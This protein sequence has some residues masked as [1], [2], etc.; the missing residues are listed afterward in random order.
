MAD[1]D[2]E[3]LSREDLVVIAINEE[4]HRHAPDLIP[5][6]WIFTDS[7]FFDRIIKNDYRCAPLTQIIT[8][9]DVAA[10]STEKDQS[11]PTT[12]NKVAW[13]TTASS[14]YPDRVARYRMQRTTATAA[15]CHLFLCGIRDIWLGG[16]D[17]CYS[18]GKSY[19]YDNDPKRVPL[20]AT[21]QN[22]VKIGDGLYSTQK[23]IQMVASMTGLKEDL[24]GTETV[25]TQGCLKSPLD[26]YPKK[27]F[28]DWYG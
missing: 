28:K 22:S 15:V 14:Y 13:F 8:H 25:I 12:Q 4:G 24:R 23:N 20:Q 7:V 9:R 6:F 17:L 1:F 2:Y 16:V 10:W 3:Q 11:F 21:K 5:D 19:Y 27:S 18:F 26:C